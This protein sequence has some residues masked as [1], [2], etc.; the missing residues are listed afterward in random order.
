MQFYFLGGADRKADTSKSLWFAR[1]GKLNTAGDEK[2]RKIKARN[3]HRL[4]TLSTETVAALKAGDLQL[5][6]IIDKTI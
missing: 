2:R 5:V 4:L 3:T 6:S 1:K